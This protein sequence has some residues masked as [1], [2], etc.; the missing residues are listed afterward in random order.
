MHEAVIRTETLPE[1]YR[2]TTT[3]TELPI[4]ATDQ[5]PRPLRL[6]RQQLAQFGLRFA[7]DHYIEVQEGQEATGIVVKMRE[8]LSRA[9]DLMK[10]QERR[11]S[12][13]WDIDNL[14][15]AWMVLDGLDEE[16][17]QKILDEKKGKNV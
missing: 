17:T 14:K 16:G 15:R 1:G 7:D 11:G 12:W 4:E 2:L 9:I 13:K 10:L 6:D 8:S 5:S 3:G